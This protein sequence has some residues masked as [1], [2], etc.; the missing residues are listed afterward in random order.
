MSPLWRVAALLVVGVTVSACA[1][2][3][4][5]LP[6]P[7]LKTVGNFSIISSGVVMATDK[8]LMDHLVSH[9]TNKDCSTVRVEQGRTYCREDEPN[10]MPNVHCYQTLGD[11]M[12]YSTPDPTRQPADVLGGQNQTQQQQQQ[13]QQQTPL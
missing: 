7:L 2:F 4:S 13:A 11:V 1:D 6:R 9:R 3:Y 8:T 5:I 12:C 10:P